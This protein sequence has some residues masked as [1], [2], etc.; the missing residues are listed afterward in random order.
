M[1]HAVRRPTFELLQFEPVHLERHGHELAGDGDFMLAGHERCP[2]LAFTA[3]Y[4]G[5][6]AGMACFTPVGDAWAYVGLAPARGVS[7]EAWGRGLPAMRTAIWKAHTQGIRRIDTMVLASF[8]PGHRLVSRLGFQFRGDHTGWDGT[9][10]AHLLY[11]HISPRL[12]ET[13]RQ[14]AA[15]IEW[16]RAMLDRHAPGALLE[17]HL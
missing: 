7:L 6:M 12:S 14:R 9:P 1:T 2:D 13:E 11:S 17:R 16:H 10:T 5:R 3:F 8:A 4:D 15:R